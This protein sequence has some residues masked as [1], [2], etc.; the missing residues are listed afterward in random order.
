MNWTVVQRI[1]GLLVMMFSLTMLPPILIAVLFKEP[2]W[3]PF[4]ESFGLTLVAGLLIWLPVHRSRRDLRLRDGFL[5]V[6]AFW[7]VLGTFGAA[8]LY[9]ADAITLSITDAVFE[10]MSGLTTTGATI[11]TGLDELPRSILYYRQQLQWLGGMGI[12]VLAVA[13]LPMLGV[14]GMQL[15]RAETPG[16]VKDTKLTPRITETAKAL[17]YV[18]LAFTIACAVSYMIAGMGWFDAL[19]HAFSTVAIGGFSTHDLSIGYFD[20]AAIDIVAIVF[21]FAAGINFSL[22]FFAWRYVSIKHYSQDPEFRAYTMILIALSMLVVAGLF[23]HRSYTSPGD[24]VINGVFQAVSIATTT[25]FTTAN[26]ATWPA[27]LPVALIFAS[28]IG[29]SAGST[30]GG[31]KVIRCLLI[32]KQGVREIARL[33]HPSAEIPVKLGNKAVGSRVVDAVWGFFSVYIVVFVVLMLLMMAAGL[34]QVT[35]FSAIAATL[36][37]LGPGLGEV[38]NGFMTVSDAA[39]WVA[40]AGMLLGRLEIFTL[41]VLISPT[42]WRH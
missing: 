20:S 1:L 10:S 30:A 5:V 31:I 12:I 29:G 16:P 33:V 39:K 11:L 40:V 21:M 38:A 7:T 14:G 23:Y 17:W 13:V 19:C 28:F 2:T 22:H 32:Y 8:P 4:V 18:Y 3:L 34:D 41:L 36:N 9:F 15:Y 24:T 6:A 27:F 37:N 25:G 35:A 26:Y 42:F